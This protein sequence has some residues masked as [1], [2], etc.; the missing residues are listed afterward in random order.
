MVVIAALRSVREGFV[1]E[2]HQ[3]HLPV[4]QMTV[5]ISRSFVG[6]GHGC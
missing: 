3:D 6:F 2:D 5:I 4:L 1:Q